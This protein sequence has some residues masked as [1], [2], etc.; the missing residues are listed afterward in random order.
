MSICTKLFLII[1]AT[2]SLIHSS[3]AHTFGQ[4]FETC[5]FK[6]FGEKILLEIKLQTDS[7]ILIL[8]PDLNGDGKL[9]LEELNILLEKLKRQLFRRIVIVNNGRKASFRVVSSNIK[10]NPGGWIYGV[11]ASFSVLIDGS[12][13][14]FFS[15]EN[16]RVKGP[17]DRIE[18]LLDARLRP[19]AYLGKNPWE[20]HARLYP[21]T[22]V[23][24][25]KKPLARVKLIREL[26][27]Q[28]ISIFLFLTA[29]FL[30]MVHALSPG[31]GKTLISAFLIGNRASAK[32]AF[33]LSLITAV[34]H[35]F[36][37]L[38]FGI[39]VYVVSPYFDVKKYFHLIQLISGLGIVLIGYWMVVRNS[40][41]VFCH[42]SHSHVHVA[43]SYKELLISGI[44]GGM[45]PCPSA[46]VILLVSIALNKLL[47]GLGV[48]V[49]FSF[50][51]AATLLLV[52]L[53]AISGVRIFERNFGNLEKLLLILSPAVVILVGVA[54]IVQ[55]LVKLT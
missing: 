27:S 50:G 42:H 25:S 37:V 8:K 54:F 52:S 5:Y 51:I 9:S 12:G 45:V 19:Q 10:P 1:S 34:T 3:L 48:I 2:I 22:K 29:V 43:L 55:S 41:A 40:K 6:P 33:L 23:S 11:T 24:E 16:F 53:L 17:K 38:L 21:V 26:Q 49:A 28:K 18:F 44:T 31:H 47:L 14:F 13:D 20:L 32:H 30:G 35:V 4:V 15:D 46:V 7:G 36:S 39:A